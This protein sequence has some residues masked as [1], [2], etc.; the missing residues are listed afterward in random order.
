MHSSCATCGHACLLTA[1]S[2]VRN[3]KT[4]ASFP[5]P[6]LLACM[7]RKVDMPACTLVAHMG[8]LLHEPCFSSKGLKGCAAQHPAPQH[9]H[10][11]GQ[12]FKCR[13][14]ANYSLQLR[15]DAHPD[16]QVWLQAGKVEGM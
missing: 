9:A 11:M 4:L 14:M 7:H 5:A 12:C 6:H 3:L 10:S 15:R 1:T 13:V 8:L 16:R 2:A